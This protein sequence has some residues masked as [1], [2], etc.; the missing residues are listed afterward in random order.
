MTRSPLRKYCSRAEGYW[1]NPAPEAFTKC[2]KIRYPS[3]CC[4]LM[5]NSLRSYPRA[6]V[7][8]G[9]PMPA[10]CISIPAPESIP[11]PELP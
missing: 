3:S 9:L 1:V 8:I 7:W 4:K 10:P 2:V 6:L 5:A 11:N